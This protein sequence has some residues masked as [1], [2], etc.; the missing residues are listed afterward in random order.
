MIKPSTDMGAKMENKYI[1][2]AVSCGKDS[3]VIPHECIRKGDKI[4]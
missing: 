4:R 3:L 2:A 1:I